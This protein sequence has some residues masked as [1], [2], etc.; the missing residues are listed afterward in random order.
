MAV[1]YPTVDEVKQAFADAISPSEP[2]D[3][4]RWSR[5]ERALMNPTWQSAGDGIEVLEANR[6]RLVKVRWA[7]SIDKMNTASEAALRASA[8]ALR[9]QLLTLANGDPTSFDTPTSDT[10]NGPVTVVRYST[11]GIIG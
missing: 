6:A 3:K 9:Q 10:E 7:F 2:F 5:L 8:A 11:I 4:Q 1:K